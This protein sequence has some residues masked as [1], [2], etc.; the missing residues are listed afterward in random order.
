MI[1]KHLSLLLFLVS[2]GLFA[3]N[4]FD[5]TLEPVTINGLNGLHSFAFGQ[6]SNG[7]WLLVGG[8]IDGLHPM[9]GNA[10]FAA[11]GNNTQLIVID[12]ATLQHWE[13]PLTSLP[14]SIQEQ[15]S[16]TNMNFYQEGD[17]LYFI[18]GYGYSATLNNHTTFPYLTAINVPQVIDAVINNTGFTSFFRQINDPEFQ[19]T[20]GILR[21]VN[22]VY[23]LL[24]GQKF[25]GRYS[26]NSNNTSQEYTNQVH[27][28]TIDD[29]GTNIVVTHLASFTDADVLHRRDLSAEAQI[30]PNGEEGVTMFSGVFQT[31]ANLPFLNPVTIDSNG[32]S[33]DN[34]FQQYYNHYQCPTIP[35]YSAGNNEMHTLFFG[36]MAQYYDDNGTLV[37]DD[38]VPFVKTIARVTRD[39]NGNM[40]EY[41]LPIEMPGYLGAGAEF[42]PVKSIPHYPNE[43]LKLDDITGNNTLIGYI[44]GGINSTQPN[45]FFSNDSSLSSAS[46][47][48]FK[49][50]LNSTLSVASHQLNPQSTG[51]L[52]MQV[53]PNPTNGVLKVD[54]KLKNT[55]NVILKITDINGRLIERKLLKNQV[56]GKNTYVHNLQKYPLGSVFFVTIQTPYETATQKIILKK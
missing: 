47:Q 5:I 31:S 43:V 23:H 17:Y 21:K 11:S 46:S 10:A 36:G 48:L 49:V 40:A 2:L 38:N 52:G 24:G 34:N 54:Y 29:D 7:K 51:I 45:I 55:G 12:P 4:P 1:K 39:A 35:L 32:Y 18:G 13:A 9:Q 6:D 37:Q 16:S 20:G 42:I 30:L 14:A 8:R 28:F 26:M 3:Q 44:F 53:Y 22:N 50:Y 41:K 27:R 25:L 56:V 15:L 33:Q 19:V